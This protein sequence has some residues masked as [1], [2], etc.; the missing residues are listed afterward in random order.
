MLSM[1]YNNLNELT[2]ET[3]PAFSG[4]PQTTNYLSNVQYYPP[5]EVQSATY[6]NGV[7]LAA[8]YDANLN[9]KDLGYLTA[10]A[11]VCNAYTWQTNAANLSSINYEATGV[12]RTFSYDQLDRIL[13]ASDSGVTSGPSL[14]ENYT[15]DPWGNMNETGNYTFSQPMGTNNQVSASGYVYDAAGNLT[16]DGLGNSY[17]VEADGLLTGSN[18]A[19]YTYDSVGQRVRKDNGSASQEY[20]YFGGVLLGMRN[21]ATANWTDHIYGA[22]RFIASVPATAAGSG[23]PTYRLG[24]HLDSLQNE[25]NTSGTI[26]TS[27]NI[28]P[29]GAL[30]AD[31]SGDEFPFTD[32]ER[33]PENG[34]DH[35]LFRQMSS[36]Q[37]RWLSP[38]PS[39]GSYSLTD[40]Q[41]LN[42]YAYLTNRPMAAVDALGLDDDDD[43]DDDTGQAA[44]NPFPSDT[45]NVPV[46]GTDIDCGGAG[47]ALIHNGGSDAANTTGSS[48]GDS[49]DTWG[50]SIGET[51]ASA[52][53]WAI[54]GPMNRA[55][56]FTDSI[57]GFNS[58][59]MLSTLAYGNESGEEMVEDEFEG[60][61][62]QVEQSA[63]SQGV[64][65]FFRTMSE[66]DFAQLQE[67]GLIPAT[68]ETFIAQDVE[69][70]GTKTYD[71]VLVQF[72]V[73]PGTTDSLLDIGVRDTSPLGL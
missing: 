6:G 20:F 29:Y 17:T 68:G 59:L 14:S 8:K 54:V 12:T 27:T 66:G 4:N 11:A 13:S 18:G 21:V 35:T 58:L 47:N 60:L 28:T 37:G 32:H 40:P 67:S 45:S 62:A 50:D 15:I 64:E 41:S 2:N 34:T 52:W 31:N 70:Y 63:F 7:S 53:N 48:S 61:W 51:I 42:R 5:G 26:T 30:L 55:T 36:A 73:Q 9:L 25:T 71:G 1:T 22:G 23:S 24:D 56:A 72:N 3:M 43:D 16:A 44:G 19:A 38:D 65:S 46:C 69:Y 39:D 57:P 10:N 49:A 33:D